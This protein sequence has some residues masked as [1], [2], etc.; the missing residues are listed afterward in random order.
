MS[1]AYRNGS[2]TTLNNAKIILFIR[3]KKDY[4]KSLNKMSSQVYHQP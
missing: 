4:D 1:P 2:I 3:K